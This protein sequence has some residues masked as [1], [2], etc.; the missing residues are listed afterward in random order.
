M[1][2]SSALVP[3]QTGMEVYTGHGDKF[4]I[5]PKTDRHGSLDWTWGQVQ[6]WSQDRQAWKSR[7]DM[8]TSSALVPR[9]TGMEVYTG[10][11]D[12]FIIGPKTDRHGSLDW[13]W[14]QVQH[15][16]QDRQAWKSLVMALC[17]FQH[18]DDQVSK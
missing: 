5:G 11:G 3:R 12:K 10:H 8:G 13:T 9:Q 14:G 6:H 1:G 15:W 18:E 16:S 17:A 4:S 7:L 2:T